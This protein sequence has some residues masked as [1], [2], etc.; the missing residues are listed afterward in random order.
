MD[1][2]EKAA[3]EYTNPVTGGPTLPTVGCWVQMLRAGEATRAHRHTASTVYH[4]VS[5]KGVTTLGRGAGEELRWGEKDCFVIPPWSWHQ[6]RNLASD[7]PAIY[8]PSR[9]VPCWRALG[10]IENSRASSGSAE[11]SVWGVRLP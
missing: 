5:G 7:E 4:N 11:L 6:H 3:K 9:T 8:S 10:S 2:V 1:E